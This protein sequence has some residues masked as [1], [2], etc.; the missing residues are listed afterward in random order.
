MPDINSL[1][2]TQAGL[3]DEEINRRALGITNF[4]VGAPKKDWWK[5]GRGINPL[6]IRFEPTIPDSTPTWADVELNDGSGS[7]AVVTGQTVGFAQ[8]TQAYMLQK[9]ALNS[10][11]ITLD[12]IRLSHMFEEQLDACFQTLTENTM[13]MWED[14]NRDE[15]VRLAKHKVIVR[16]G[17]TENDSAFPTSVATGRVT[18]DILRHFYR[19]LI[20]RNAGTEGGAIEMVNGLPQFVC[21]A[22]PEVNDTIIRGDYQVREDFRNTPRSNELLAGLGVDRPYNG[23]FHVNDFKAPRWNFTGGAWVRVPYWTTEA[24]TK[25]TRAIPNP[26]Y[27][28]ATYEDTILFVP[29]VYTCEYLKPL[30]KPGGNTEFEAKDYQGKWTFNNFGHDT[31]NPD[32][33]FGRFRGLFYSAS[34]P[35]NPEVGYVLRGLRPNLVT[36]FVDANGDVVA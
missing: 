22:S 19:R 20:D 30:P 16:D 33:N 32:R 27:E 23:F 5:D 24:T 7:N 36:G 4:W 25:G 29:K 34:K 14:R 1:L 11:Y 8:T 28:T 6:A 21:V 17:F 18:G 35:I 12:D 2:Q 9:A 26:A 10:P 3:L 15:Y 13:Q 31:D